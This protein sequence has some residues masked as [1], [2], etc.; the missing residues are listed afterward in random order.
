MLDGC[1]EHPRTHLLTRSLQ[2]VHM[3]LCMCSFFVQCWGN[4]DKGGSTSLWTHLLL[5]V[6][7]YFDRRK[8]RGV[9]C[10]FSI[11]KRVGVYVYIRPHTHTLHRWGTWM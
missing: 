3:H 9:V 6:G 5:G 4:E 11:L 1:C 7:D 10:V 2:D 8:D